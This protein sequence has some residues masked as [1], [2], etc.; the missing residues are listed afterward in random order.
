MTTVSDLYAIILAGGSG[1]RLWPLS[2]ELHPKQLMKIE[3]D[4][5]L[6]QSAFIRL[7][8]SV[9]DK[10]ILS[11]TNVKLES[12]VKSQLVEMQEKF[13]RKS[14]Y[15]VITEPECRGTA[16][17]IAL[18]IKYIEKLQKD[19]NSKDDP[20][21]IAVPSDN[22]ISD[23]EQFAAAIKEAIKLAK[24]NYIVTFGVKPD[25]AD[26]GLGYIK[27]KNNKKIKDIT[28]V[29]LKV[30]T[31]IEKPDK[32]TA[33]EFV[34]S[35]KYYW[36]SGMFVFKASVMM[37]ELKKYEPDIF[38]IIKNA[39]ISSQT[40]TIPYLDF[41]EM[42]D[43][44]ID[45]AVMENSKKLAMVPLECDWRD[46][47]SW[48]AIYAISEKDENGNYVMGNVIDLDSK[49]SM[50]YSTSKLITTIGLNNVVVVE[51]EDA[52]LVC[53]R[54]RTQDVKKIVN[55]LKERHD[56]TQLTHKTVY[57]PWGYYTVLNEGK[58]FLTK[59]I[60]VNPGAKLSVQ[61]HHHR[62]EHWVVV[63]GKALVL[64]GEEYFELNNG[65]SI[66]LAVEEKHSLQNPY[67]EPLKILE[68]QKG[69]ILDENDIVRFED[70]Y[71]RV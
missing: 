67:D 58:G 48:E 46:V 40:P 18:S 60:Y 33:Q 62:S 16:P 42:P 3:G 47:G 69:D 71:G 5:T 30:D 37:A 6:F 25:R 65:D 20:I 28:S 23:D 24:E 63:E 15:R 45:Y 13:C 38:S 31:F 59:C 61:L 64:K 54:E 8:N 34:D 50:V 11:V 57:R 35:D 22:L 1:T 21:I 68:V 7:V 70:M 49:N 39:E 51:T 19:K 26:T 43:I 53:D 41:K 44:S 36:N 55:H 66:D 29:G 14:N 10:N 4:Y 52:L 56:E 32:E 12:Q 27:T 17:A 9:D 2:R